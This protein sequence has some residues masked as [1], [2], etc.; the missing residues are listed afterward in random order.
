MGMVLYCLSVTTLFLLPLFLVL[1]GINSVFSFGFPD[2]TSTVPFVI[3]PDSGVITVSGP[4]DF[5]TT[6]QYSF[7]VRMGHLL[8]ES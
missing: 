6:Q 5:E 7:M 4:L 3:N 8:L 2:S 1:Q